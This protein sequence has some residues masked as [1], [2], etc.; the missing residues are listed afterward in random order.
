M[1]VYYVSPTGSDSN[2]GGPLDDPF[3]SLQQAADLSEPGD[4]ILLRGGEY[5]LSAGVHLTHS[6]TS[7]APITIAN[8]EGEHPILD[9][10]DVGYDGSVITL[11]GVDW[12]HIKGLE[13]RN[14]ADGGLIMTN[15]SQNTIEQLDVHDN[16]WLSQ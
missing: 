4:T 15:S 9:G 14:G 13:I 11:D 16:G 8:Y 7:D 3:A 2:T 1:T 12:T 6:G 5:Y 10:S